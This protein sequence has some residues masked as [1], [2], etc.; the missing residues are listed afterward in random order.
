VNKADQK[1]ITTQNVLETVAYAHE[2][3]NYIAIGKYPKLDLLGLSRRQ[4]VLRCHA[5]CLD[6]LIKLDLIKRKN[7]RYFLTLFGQVV[8]NIQLDLSKA[9]DYRFGSNSSITKVSKLVPKVELNVVNLPPE[10]SPVHT[11]K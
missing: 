10:V 6:R 4:S 8:H 5:D 3:F 2:L 11:S 9:T 1:S 7:G